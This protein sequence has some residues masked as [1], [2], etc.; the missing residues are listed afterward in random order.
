MS[1]VPFG[2]FLI[3]IKLVIRFLIIF[4]LILEVSISILFSIDNIEMDTE[5]KTN[6]AQIPKIPIFVKTALNNF[7]LL[8]IKVEIVCK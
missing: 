4:N 2:L 8:L 3:I 7:S 6:E 1:I 5:F